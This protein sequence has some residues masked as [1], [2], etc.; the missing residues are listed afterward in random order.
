MINTAAAFRTAAVPLT[1]RQ[2]QVMHLAA[3]GYTTK[4]IA[5]IL[6]ISRKTVEKHRMVAYEALGQGVNCIQRVI[7]VMRYR[8]GVDLLAEPPPVGNNGANGSRIILRGDH[9][10]A[11]QC[12]TIVEMPNAEKGTLMPLVRLDIGTDVVVASINQMG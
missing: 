12:G 8:H 1:E 11:G 9:P 3:W 6:G 5:A 4:A 10:F 2:L 7:I